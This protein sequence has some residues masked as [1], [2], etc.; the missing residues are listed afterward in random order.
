MS[1]SNKRNPPDSLSDHERA[2][3]RREV[4][5]VAPLAAPARRRQQRALPSARPR[6]T[7]ADEAAVLAQ[8]LD[9]DPEDADANDELVFRQPGVQLAV[10]RRLRRGHYRCQ[11]ELD[12]H[13]LFV[14]TAR[15]AT[16][17]FLAASLDDGHRCVRIVTGKGL[18]SGQRGPVLRN[19]V[20]GWLR[21]RREV[22]AFTTARRVDGG[23]GALYVLLRR[24]RF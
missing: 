24:P 16:A 14:A 19:K 6:S 5:A 20:A 17:R 8:L 15:Q 23:T 2:L 9:A 18:G 11:G 7:E 21:Q 10:M 13:G 3:F 22:L 1:H 4:G 12:L